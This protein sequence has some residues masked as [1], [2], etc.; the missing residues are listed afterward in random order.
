MTVKSRAFTLIELLVVIAI[1]AILAAILFPVFSQA[2]ESA[3]KAASISNVKQLATS[4]LLYINDSDDL[5]PRVVEDN[6]LSDSAQGIDYD[7]SWMLKLQPYVKNID[8]FF[9]PASPNQRRPQ[10][11]AP[12]SSGGIIFNYAMLPR[13]QIWSGNSNPGFWQTGFATAL[14][15]GIGGYGFEPGTSYFGGADFCGT[16]VTQAQKVSP[17]MSQTAVGRPAETALIMDARGFDYGITCVN[18][19]PAP[20]DALP[21][22]YGAALEGINF[23]G[24]YHKEPN[25]LFNGIPYRMGTATVSFVDG[26]AA[27]VK[28]GRFFDTITLGDGRLAYR[29]Q[30]SRE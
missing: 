26:H 5:F 25:R 11:T 1:I 6:A 2:K 10:F 8:I 16:G 21:P 3:K 14:F 30:Y 15:D 29:Y 18:V 17:S 4:Q 13:W 19:Y 20:S 23:E 28:T 12:R 7:A 9:S 22:S 27:A 24:R